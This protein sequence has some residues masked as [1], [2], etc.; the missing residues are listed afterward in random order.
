MNDQNEVDGLLPSTKRAR[1]VKKPPTPPLLVTLQVS[2]P[3]GSDYVQPPPLV[4]GTTGAS[5]SG[6]HE[7]MTAFIESLEADIDEQVGPYYM[8]ICSENYRYGWIWPESNSESKDLVRR[9]ERGI[10]KGEVNAE[11]QT[12]LKWSTVRALQRYECEYFRQLDVY[13]R[14]S[15]LAS[16]GEGTGLYE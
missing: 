13:T 7:A 14:T 3:C 8:L 1:T 15:S 9:I 10:E 11:L 5:I 2:C 6:T 4:C 16:C 12:G